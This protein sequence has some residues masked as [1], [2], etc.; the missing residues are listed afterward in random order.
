MTYN[1]DLRISAEEALKHPWFTRVQEK[2]DE[3]VGNLTQALDNLKD[4]NVGSKLK[5][6][7]HAFLTK[8]LLTQKE[9]DELTEQFK[10]IDVNGDGTLSRDELLAAYQKV[11]GK[12]FSPDEVDKFIAKVDTD[13][14]GVIN[15][16]E[17]LVAAIDKEFLVEHE[18]L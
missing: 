8:F 10:A 14:N 18:R 9:K 1:P 4:F 15:Y 7:V 13:G 11:K 3:E 6:A 12:S 2:K 16:S 17:W 5:Q